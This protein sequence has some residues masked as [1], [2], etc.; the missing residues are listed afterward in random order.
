MAPPHLRWPLA[1]SIAAAVVTIAMKGTAYAVTGSVGL[2]SDALESGVNLFAAVTAYLSL[3]YA[4]RPADPSHT[5]G[6]EKIEYLSSGLEGALILAAGLGTAAYA[7]RRL[8]YPEAL[9]NLEIGTAI[10]V[11]ASAVNFVAARVLLHYGR[12]HRS[13]I[14]EADGKHL[15]SD[16]WT[17][18]GVVGGIGLV[19]LTKL[20][21]LDAV[22]AAVVGLNIMWTGGELIRRSFDGLMDHALPEAE[23]EQIRSVI[24]A[25]LPPGA[26]FHALRTRQAGARR[27]AEFHFLVAGDLSVRDAH[28]LG[29][30]I[31]DA[32][33]AALPGLE[34]VFHVEPV[35]ERASWED[36][37]LERLGEP[38]TPPPAPEATH[39]R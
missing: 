19:L 36:E 22:V 35:D 13:I 27:F 30:T 10:A 3:L 32:L 14:L 17:S 23:Q 4:A 18:V 33:V 28:H 7:V 15:M 6:H 5:Y 29:H 8:I 21:F 1:I 25:H 2:F 38:A 16:V 31:E 26:T 9:A 24:A 34:V 20:D 39:D 11:A 12:K 37:Y